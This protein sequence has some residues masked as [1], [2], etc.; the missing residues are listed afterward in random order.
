MRLHKSRRNI[1]LRD[2][3]LKSSGGSFKTKSSCVLIRPS[4]IAR[5][6]SGVMFSSAVAS[7][8]A[9]TMYNKRAFEKFM[10]S[11]AFER[12]AA[13]ESPHKFIINVRDITFESLSRAHYDQRECVAYER[14]FTCD[15]THRKNFLFYDFSGSCRKLLFISLLRVCL[16]DAF[17]NI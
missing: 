13:T 2:W 16:W 4:I 9:S 11:Y 1:A 12:E 17:I 3:N 15:E 5:L 7:N 8:A 10:T 14:A 6:A